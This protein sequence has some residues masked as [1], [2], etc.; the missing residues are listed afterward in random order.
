MCVC[1][2]ARVWIVCRGTAGGTHSLSGDA[3]E[4]GQ[5]WGSTDIQILKIF[6]GVLLTM[7]WMWSVISEKLSMVS[8]RLD[9]VVAMQRK[10]PPKNMLRH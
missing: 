2:R 9:Q 6:V 7:R 3:G 1:A 10:Q 5:V 8:W 4:T